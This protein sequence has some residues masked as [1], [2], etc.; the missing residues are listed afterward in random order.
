MIN[1]V[2]RVNSTTVAD[3]FMLI[4]GSIFIFASITISVVLCLIQNRKKKK[5]KKMIDKLEVEKN[6]LDTSPIAPEL[7]KLEGYLNNDKIKAKYEDWR[8]RLDYIKTKQI[9]AITNML[10]EAEYSLNKMDYK[11]SMC[12]IA[13]LEM[14]IYKV[15]SNS[16]ILLE[17]IMDVTNSEEKNRTLITNLKSEYRDLY[18]KYNSS[19]NDFGSAAK[20]VGLQF[21]NIS[22]RFEV[23]E[24]LM[25]NNDYLE[26]GNVIKAIEEMLE[27]MKTVLDEVPPIV[28][29]AENILPKRISELKKTYTDMLN[30]HYPLDYLNIDYNIVEANNK[31]NDV[32]DRLKVLNLEDSLFELKVLMEY[33]DGVFVDL[34]KEKANRQTYEEMNKKLKRKSTDV[35]N[36]VNQI[37]NQLDSLIA[38]YNLSANDV[39][40]LND[41]KNELEVLNT[42]YKVLV[43]HTSNHAFAYSKLIQ[44]ID[45]L[46]TRFDNLQT[47]LESSLEAIGSVREDES[48]AYQ[49]QDEII[50]IL[51]DS[52]YKIRDYDF[53]VIPKSYYVETKEASEALKE[54]KKELSRKPI[55]IETLNT[56][57]DTARDLAL[58]LYAK[59][60]DMVKNA[61]L[62]ETAIVYGNR[63]RPLSVDLDRTLMAAEVLF[64]KGD[65]LKSLEVSINA[66]NQIDHGVYDKLVSTYNEYKGH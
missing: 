5:Y 8:D 21:E 22:K 39:K 23:F 14:E 63:Y 20:Y 52:K 26:L 4:M 32:V 37:F 55:A 62:A 40:I 56:R 1:E 24:N 42:D 38:T 31:I 45:D 54:L 12:K 51:K 3:N 46:Y 50:A 28:L 60:K 43:T 2:I 10:L 59:T 15:R 47:K 53:P 49:Q 61:M 35:N 16:E 34:D 41:T 17:E 13:K 65:Y 64:N 29:L 66:L 33:F 30:D 6:Q 48:R 19:I 27:H 25:D 18:N 58:K 11:S 7:D 36:L 9:P 44:E 57:V